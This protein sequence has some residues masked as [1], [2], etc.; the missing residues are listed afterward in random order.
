MGYRGKTAEQQRA[1]ELRAQ[2]WTYAEI[3]S[4][5][6]VSRSS[7]SLWV[8]DVAVDEIAWSRRVRSNGNFGPRRRGPNK[9]QVAKQR[10]IDECRRRA[11]AWLGGLSERDLLVAGTALYAGEGSKNDGSGVRFANSDPRMI[12]LFVTWLRRFFDIDESRLRVKLYLHEGLDLDAANVFWSDLVDIPIS[13][14]N[15]PYRAVPDPTI[16]KAKHLMGCPCIVYT[17][18]PTHRLVMGLV[19]SLLSPT[20]IDPG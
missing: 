15:R 10:E 11:E 18:S 14:F 2:G 4:E 8:R 6:G 9:L 5:L 17:S 13:Q 7:I 1:R 12:V 3:Q 20:Q 16:R 19:E